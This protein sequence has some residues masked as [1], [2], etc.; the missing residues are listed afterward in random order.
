[1]AQ[2]GSSAGVCRAGR[3]R[4]Q[5]PLPWEE[6]CG[7]AQPGACRLRTGQVD[8]SSHLWERFLPGHMPYLPPLQPDILEVIVHLPISTKAREETPVGCTVLAKRARG[9]ATTGSA[10]LLGSADLSQLR[11]RWGL[12]T[13]KD[14]PPPA[15]EGQGA[16]MLLVARVLRPES[17]HAVQFLRHALLP[18]L[19]SLSLLFHILGEPG[20]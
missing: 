3:S 13:G 15:P 8:S 9:L 18:G 20:T 12:R 14:H 10:A 16:P 4:P 19:H 1:M 17:H 11:V 7:G 6:V 5:V 2:A